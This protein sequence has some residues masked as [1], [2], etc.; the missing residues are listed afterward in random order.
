MP[1]EWY[2]NMSCVAGKKLEQTLAGIKG[3]SKIHFP[4]SQFQRTLTMNNVA[5]LLWPLTPTDKEEVI[6]IL[7]DGN[8]VPTVVPVTKADI[9]LLQKIVECRTS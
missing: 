6:L 3:D 5:A 1:A 7:V 4:T 8:T 2:K 9:D